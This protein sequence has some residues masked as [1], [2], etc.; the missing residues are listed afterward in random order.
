MGELIQPH[1]TMKRSYGR[2]DMDTIKWFGICSK[3]R[4]LDHTARENAAMI[5]EKFHGDDKVMQRVAKLGE[6]MQPRK[7][8]WRAYIDLIKRKRE[9]MFS[10]ILV[11]NKDTCEFR[12]IRAAINR[13]HD[14]G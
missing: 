10:P 13:Q 6:R 11:T 8:S 12:C 3:I 5:W 4:E 2:V 7:A 1:K 14:K 9:E